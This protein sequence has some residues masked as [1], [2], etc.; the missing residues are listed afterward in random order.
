MHSL[1]SAN[2]FGSA[3]SGVLVVDVDRL[4]HGRQELVA[5]TA[6]QLTATWRLVPVFVLTDDDV[7]Q[8]RDG[9]THDSMFEALPARGSGRPERTRRR[10][11][12]ADACFLRNGFVLWL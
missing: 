5:A 1:T 6:Q 12:G 3:K 2:G 9:K 11:A 10:P 8:Q 7:W 4:H